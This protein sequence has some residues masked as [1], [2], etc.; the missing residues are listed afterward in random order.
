M[1]FWRVTF[2]LQLRH[3]VTYIVTRDI[4]AQ[5]YSEASVIVDLWLPGT[6]S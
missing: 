3:K 4:I 5:A 2:D 1:C 6:L